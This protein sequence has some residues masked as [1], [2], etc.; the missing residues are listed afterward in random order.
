[1]WTNSCAEQ[2]PADIPVEQPT[3]FQLVINLKSAKALS[4]DVPP[5]LR[6]R[7]D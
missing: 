3:E 6:R 7:G 1:M 4:L 5:L 2:R